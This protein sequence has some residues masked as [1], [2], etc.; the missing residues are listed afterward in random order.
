MFVDH[1]GCQENID[2]YVHNSTI[3]LCDGYKTANLVLL[4]GG[5]HFTLL[6][7]AMAQVVSYK[8]VISEGQFHSQASPCGIITGWSGTGTGFSLHTD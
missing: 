6:D 7:Y 1:E 2:N 5:K 8:P 3:W 4:D